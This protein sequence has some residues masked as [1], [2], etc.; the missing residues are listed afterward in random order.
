M[1]TGGSGQGD[2]KIESSSINISTVSAYFFPKS[3]KTLSEARSDLS[4][5][6]VDVIEV[7]ADVVEVGVDIDAWPRT[8]L[9]ERRGCCDWS[10]LFVAFRH[11]L[12]FSN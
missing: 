7:G 5:A 8:P 12:R 10:T 2:L 11:A 1:S 6:A 9:R 3:I 4:V